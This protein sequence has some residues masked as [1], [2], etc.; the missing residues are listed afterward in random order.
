MPGV[1]HALKTVHKLTVER[2][3]L[4]TL[5]DRHAGAVVEAALAAYTD[6]NTHVILATPVTFES[7]IEIVLRV[8]LAWDKMSPVM[9]SCCTFESVERVEEEKEA[10]K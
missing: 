3:T 1:A 5:D 6:T 9:M 2:W 7:G 4:Q 10:V 8:W